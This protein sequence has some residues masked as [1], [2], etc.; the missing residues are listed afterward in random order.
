MTKLSYRQV[1]AFR[2]VMIA[3]TTTGA[4]E[5]LYISQPAVSR[6]LN[7]FEATVNVKLFERHHKRLAPTPEAL[8]LFEE[9]ERSFIGI[10]R[11][12]TMA[13]E[14]RDFQRGSLK[15]A[16]M[17]AIA[18]GFLP[19]VM[20]KFSDSHQ[21]VS[22]TLQVRSSQQVADWIA[23][24]HFDVGIGAINVVDPALS[25]EVLGEAALVCAL[26]ARHPLAKKAVI[27][28]EDLRDQPFISL[29]P[30]Q[31]V[32]Y[33]VDEAFEQARVSRQLVFDTQLSHVACSFV[34][35]GA[36]VALVDPITALHFPSANLVF[37]PFEPWIS[38]SYHLLFPAS[39]PRSRITQEFSQLL[40]SEL[41]LLTE[42]S[43]GLLRLKDMLN[44]P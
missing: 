14:L 41:A 7:D 3:G 5:L 12:A 30:E 19:R 40:R 42:Q 18:L 35:A 37:R 9:V 27:V 39:R 2:A 44:T 21:G 6:L 24:Q 34:D 23:T 36:G 29:G 1:E 11:L 16:A 20:Q 38:F 31:S 28:P 13:E 15:V 22:H 8:L 33:K 25:V 43:S 32:R 4:A 26:P 10:D 17:P